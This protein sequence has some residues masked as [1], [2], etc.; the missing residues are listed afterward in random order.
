MYFF[1][2]ICVYYLLQPTNTHIILKYILY[3]FFFSFLLVSAG[4][5]PQGAYNQLS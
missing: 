1:D 5:N 2:Y 3:N 4:L